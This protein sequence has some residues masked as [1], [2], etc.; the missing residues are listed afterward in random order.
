MY[1]CMYMKSL[2]R[3]TGRN[4]DGVQSNSWINK[5]D[6]REWIHTGKIKILHRGK[7]GK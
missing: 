1:V 2:S 3:V 5:I 4:C 6:R 7:R